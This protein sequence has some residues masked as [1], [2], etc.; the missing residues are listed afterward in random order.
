M[1]KHNVVMSKEPGYSDVLHLIKGDKRTTIIR[2]ELRRRYGGVDLSGLAWKINVVN[3]AGEEDVFTPSSEVVVTET[4]IMVE[5]MPRGVATSHEGQTQYQL[6]G[7]GIDDDGEPMECWFAEKAIWV[8]EANEVE[9]SEE[10]NESIS[11]LDEL[12]ITVQNDLPTVYAARDA[13]VAAADAANSAAT[14]TPRISE[15]GTWLI[16]DGRIGAYVDSEKT[17]IGKAGVGIA[18]IAQT[19][20]GMGGG[21]MNEW[22]ITLTDGTK[23][24]ITLYNGENGEKGDPGEPGKKGDDGFSPRVELVSNT[25]SA[26]TLKITNA[27]GSYAVEIPKGMD[28]GTETELRGLIEALEKNKLNA[29]D[30]VDSHEIKDSK[31]ALSANQGVVIYDLAMSAR[32]A[33]IDKSKVRISETDTEINLTVVQHDGSSKEVTIPKTPPAI[34][35]PDDNGGIANITINGEGPDENGNFVI[36]TLTDSEIAALEYFMT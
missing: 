22:I 19:V 24:Y 9:A 35:V 32:S 4:D 6:V 14:N 21:A 23:E 1:P 8:G 30:V 20:M 3:A 28:D 27:D 7:V 2:M 17:A 10:Q 16:Y 13:A 31:K 15:N 33:A 12:I 36:N 34:D 18:S 5:W 29:S 11:A 26:I 25:D